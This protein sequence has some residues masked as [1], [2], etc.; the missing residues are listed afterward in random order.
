MQ[1]LQN[2]VMR[3]MESSTNRTIMK[4]SEQF[5]YLCYN[6]VDLMCLISLKT[7]EYLTESFFLIY[8]TF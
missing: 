3:E 7:I 8:S 5:S 2:K 1:R 4:Y 6:E